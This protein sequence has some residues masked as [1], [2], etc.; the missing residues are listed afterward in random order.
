[1]LHDARLRAENQ[2]DANTLARIESEIAGEIAQ[3]VAFAEAGTFE[4]V[5]ELERFVYS[6]ALAR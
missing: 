4:P 5:A 1:M 2:L 3:A 6:E